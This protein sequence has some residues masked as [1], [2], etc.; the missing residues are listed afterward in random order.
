MIWD[1]IWLVILLVIIAFG[2][3]SL[4]RLLRARQDSD[5]HKYDGGPTGGNWSCG[6]GGD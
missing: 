4:I 6:G 1:N 2:G 3:W 5:D